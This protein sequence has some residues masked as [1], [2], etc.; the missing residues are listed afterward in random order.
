MAVKA[1]VAWVR[2]ILIIFPI[3]LLGSCNE[4]ASN[5][6]TLFTPVPSGMS[7][8]DFANNITTDNDV[9]ILNYEYLYNGAGIGVA[10]FNRFP[11]ALRAHGNHHV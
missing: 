5:A 2:S 10:D 7:G 3:F 8:I 9:N 4:E 11:E 6:G 1:Y